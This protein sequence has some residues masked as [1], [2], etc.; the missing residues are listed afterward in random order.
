MSY[1]QYRGIK[2]LVFAPI[3]ADTAESYTTGTVFSVPGIKTLAKSTT[4]N[5]ETVNADDL[6][7]LVVNSEG[8]S[9][10]QIE[11]TGIPPEIIADLTGQTYL[12]N[13]GALIEGQ[14]QLKYFANWRVL[15]CGVCLRHFLKVYEDYY[16]FEYFRCCKDQA[17]Q[18]DPGC[19]CADVIKF[20]QMCAVSEGN[21][22]TWAMQKG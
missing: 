4:T 20:G 5:T 22:W 15:V 17:P 10:Y 14:R 6:P 2:D 13:Y 11:T 9:T 3:T 8:E 18:S 16:D 19:P 1:F 12:D 21:V 7:V